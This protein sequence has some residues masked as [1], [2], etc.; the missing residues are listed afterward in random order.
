M[1]KRGPAP[2]PTAIKDLRGTRRKDRELRNAPDPDPGIPEL[3]DG[4]GED[5]PWGGLAVEEYWAISPGLL[6]LGL[7]S[8]IDKAALLGYCDAF[9]RWRYFRGK[10]QDGATFVTDKG[11]EGIKPEMILLERA[12][13]QMKGFLSLFG[14]SPSDRTRVTSIANQRG[15]DNPF[16][17]FLK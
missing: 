8:G 12:E 4:W 13:K 5:C 14:L 3:P 6:K 15:D 7:L 16:A 1:G 9:A 2:L 10:V 17:G 11:Y